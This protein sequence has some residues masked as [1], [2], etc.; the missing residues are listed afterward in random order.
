MALSRTLLLLWRRGGNSLPSKLRYG[1]NNVRSLPRVGHVRLSTKVWDLAQHVG[2]KRDSTVQT[3]ASRNLKIR[4]LQKSS[5]PRWMMTWTMRLGFRWNVGIQWT[6]LFLSKSD[7]ENERTVTQKKLTAPKQPP[8]LSQT[9][10]TLQ[11]TQLEVIFK[12]TAT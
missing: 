10:Q 6:W 3:V 2:E 12:S 1:G 4:T 9:L 8:P 7:W 5:L 11:V